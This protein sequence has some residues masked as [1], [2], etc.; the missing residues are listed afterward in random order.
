MTRVSLGQTRITHKIDIEITGKRRLVIAVIRDEDHKKR[1][2][3]SWFLSL[4]PRPHKIE[5]VSVRAQTPVQPYS[6]V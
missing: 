4:L 3:G 5:V 1:A 6:Q 2:T